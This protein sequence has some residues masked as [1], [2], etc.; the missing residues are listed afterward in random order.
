MMISC[1]RVQASGPKVIHLGDSKRVD[2]RIS[3]LRDVRLSERAG[4][5]VTELEAKERKAES[6]W[7]LI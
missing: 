7:V 3:S 6:P 1:Y 2:L 4:P 5:R